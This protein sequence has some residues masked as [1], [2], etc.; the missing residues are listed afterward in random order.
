MFYRVEEYNNDGYLDLLVIT[1]KSKA[2]VQAKYPE[3]KVKLVSDADSIETWDI[4][5]MESI[6]KIEVL[7]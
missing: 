4:A 7:K 5:D 3:A 2:E 6:T 1:E